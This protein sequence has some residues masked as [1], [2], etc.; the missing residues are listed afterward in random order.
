MLQVL[1]DHVFGHFAYR[2]AKI[3]SSPEVPAPIVLFQR[4]KLFKHLAGRP[5]FDPPHDLTRGQLGR[6][7]DQNVE[8][9][10]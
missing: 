5:F 3:P 1:L 8:F 10:G 2:R 9:G 4:R 6:S 7:R